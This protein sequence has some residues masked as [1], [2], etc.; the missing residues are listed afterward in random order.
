MNGLIIS[1]SGDPVSQV[2]DFHK[3]TYWIW[4]KETESKQ[5]SE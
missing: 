1:R 4:K 5:L 3:G 2:K